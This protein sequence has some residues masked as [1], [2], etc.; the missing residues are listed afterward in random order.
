[1]LTQDLLLLLRAIQLPP[2]HLSPHPLTL[3]PTEYLLH[4]MEVEAAAAVV[5]AA[6]ATIVVVV[7]DPLCQDTLAE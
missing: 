5:A 7:E 6:Q 1:M 2:Q 3:A 4:L